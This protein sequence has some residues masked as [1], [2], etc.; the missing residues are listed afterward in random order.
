MVGDFA[1][2]GNLSLPF[3]LLGPYAQNKLDQV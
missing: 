2:D 3:I 1:Y